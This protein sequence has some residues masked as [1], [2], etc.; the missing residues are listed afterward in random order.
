MSKKIQNLI[1][2]ETYVAPLGMTVL[3]AVELVSLHSEMK[4]RLVVAD[5][6]TRR[7]PGCAEYR[8][9]GVKATIYADGLRKVEFT[10]QTF[11]NR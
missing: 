10:G 7:M 1:I 2:G 8:A 4:T 6:I 3:N 11:W 9:D 5:V